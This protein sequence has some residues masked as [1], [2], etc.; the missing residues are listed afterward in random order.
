MVRS[1]GYKWE[2]VPWCFML[3]GTSRGDEKERRGKQDAN[4]EWSHG[5]E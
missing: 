5:G 1:V 4:Y 2:L 3:T